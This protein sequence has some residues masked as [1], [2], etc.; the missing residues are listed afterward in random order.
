MQGVCIWSVLKPG[1][2]FARAFLTANGLIRGGGVL[3]CESP[4][5]CFALGQRGF[6]CL[7]RQFGFSN[8][9][10][11]TLVGFVFGV[12]RGSTVSNCPVQ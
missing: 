8:C 5:I 7:A 3:L 11:L 12:G 2:S 4:G 1:F 10:N 6:G 9:R